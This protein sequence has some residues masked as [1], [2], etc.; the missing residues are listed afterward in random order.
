VPAINLSLQYRPVKIG[1]LV[2][3]GNLADVERAAGLNT[4]LWGGFANPLIPVG[5]ESRLTKYLIEAF[6][7]D[8]LI[9]VED[10]PELAAVVKEHKYLEPPHH[11]G[12]PLFEEE[13]RSKKRV[14]KYLDVINTVEACWERDFQHKDAGYTSE[15]TLVRWD[16]ADSFSTL[17]SI[18]FGYYGDFGTLPD[19]EKAFIEGMKGKEFVI[20]KDANIDIALASAVTPMVATRLELFSFWAPS[21][22]RDGVYVGDERSFVDLVEFWNIRAAGASVRFLPLGA[23]QRCTDVVR[24]HMTRLDTRRAAHP[25]FDDSISV[26]YRKELETQVKAALVGHETKRRTLWRRTDIY[27]WNGLNTKPA[28]FHFGHKRILGSQDTQFGRSVVNFA[29]PEKDFLAKRAVGRQGSDVDSQQLA[30]SLDFYSEYGYEGSTLKPP[31]IRQLNEFYSRE[32]SMDP[33]KLRVERDGIA[34]LDKVGNESIS[35]YPLPQQALVEQVFGHAGIEAKQS[36]AGLLAAHIIKSMRETSA[37]EACRVFKVRGARALLRDLPAGGHVGWEDAIKLIGREEFGKFTDL[38]IASR[39][40]KNLEPADVL[41]FLL[42]KR[43]LV[44]KLTAIARLFGSKQRIACADCGLQSEIAQAAFEGYWECPYCEHRQYLPSRIGEHFKDKSVWRIEKRG[45]FAKDNNQEGAIP[46]ILTLLAL[47]RVLDR[48]GGF[49]HTTS[50]NLAAGVR[51]ET[52]LCVMQYRDDREIE[53][54][55]G[56]CKSRGKITAKDI[57]NLKAQ[58]EKL[59]AVDLRC[60]LV[61]SKADEEFTPEEIELF[62]ALKKDRVPFILFTRRELEPYHPYWRD[63]EK[64]KLPFPHAFKLSDLSLNSEFLYLPR[65]KA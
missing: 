59:E 61:F 44:P 15:C 5:G 55:I 49:V 28:T 37:L 11:W 48:G 43:I 7:V 31:F 26:Y 52:D 64:E 60:H 50:L 56:E 16:K 19:F 32:I 63:E 46:V 54:A 58:R 6:A 10:V 27:S 21:A 39:E 2:R 57:A 34:I 13:W 30:V 1:F 36:Q 65:K 45:L 17:F 14:L 38:Y 62:Q 22:D 20:A 35:V 47:N 42:D 25:N 12:D 9:P 53:I 8:V 23:P 51:C 33:W 24:A 18:L 40:R 3:D 29:L 4:M 41:N